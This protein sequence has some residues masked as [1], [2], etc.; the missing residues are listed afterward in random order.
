MLVQRGFPS[1]SSGMCIPMEKHLYMKTKHKRI[2]LS[3]FV[4]TKQIVKWKI[5]FGSKSGDLSAQKNLPLSF[6][7][8]QS[9]T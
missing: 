3:E 9:P 4:Y 8:S 6:S 1:D 5:I 7:A 2:W